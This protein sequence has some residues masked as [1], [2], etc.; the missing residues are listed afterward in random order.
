[1]ADVLKKTY[2]VKVREAGTYD[3]YCVTEIY[4]VSQDIVNN[5]T[6][7]R[8]IV[9]L[10]CEND[11]SYHLDNDGVIEIKVAGVRS[12]YATGLTGFDF[13]SYTSKQIYNATATVL[14]DTDGTFS[15]T[16]STICKYDST[17]SYANGTGSDTV[18][19]DTIPRASEIGTISNFNLEDTFSVPVDKKSVSFTDDLVIKQGDTAIKTITDY[20]N[21]ASINLTDSELLAAYNAIDKSASFTFQTT[22]K[23]GSA[24]IGTDSAEATGTAAGTAYIR[25][26]EMW[27]R[28]LPYIKVNGVWKKSIANIKSG[29]S[30]KRGIG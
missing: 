2:S 16:F 17:G 9:T 11:A 3:I 26:G 14:N 27:K 13:R 30:W 4:Q 20:T 21:G 25:T 7:Y 15:E 8:A 22:T 19:F 6:T 18:A 24:T 1:M 23:S 28:A 12:L 29:G 10:T 5:R